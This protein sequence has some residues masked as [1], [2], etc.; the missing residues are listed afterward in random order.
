MLKCRKA[1][2]YGECIKTSPSIQ[3]ICAQQDDHS[4]PDADVTSLTPLFCDTP[5]MS[6]SA[7]VIQNDKG[8]NQTKALTTNATRQCTEM[9][10]TSQWLGFLCVA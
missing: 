3:E 8:I 7:V 4:M 9:K 2:H 1:K 6:S 5:C 10:V